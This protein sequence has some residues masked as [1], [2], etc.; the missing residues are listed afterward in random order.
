MTCES[1]GWKSALHVHWDEE[2]RS[3]GKKNGS[4]RYVQVVAV[5]TGITTTASMAEAAG[6]GS[7]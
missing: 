7:V 2:C 4:V 1:S 3:V 6:P 5:G